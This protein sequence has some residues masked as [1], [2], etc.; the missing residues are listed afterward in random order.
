MHCPKCFTYNFQLNPNN[1]PMLHVLTLSLCSRWECQVYRDEI[2]CPRVIGD[3]QY[4]KGSN[5]GTSHSVPSCL[6]LSCGP[7]TSVWVLWKHISMTGG[8]VMPKQR[9]LCLFLML[10]FSSFL[11]LRE[12]RAISAIQLPVIFQINSLE[13]CIEVRDSSVAPHTQRR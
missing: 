2:T 7:C 11:H 8:G 9:Y 12:H 6:T 4:H 10:N 5:P 3:K 13:M 1:H